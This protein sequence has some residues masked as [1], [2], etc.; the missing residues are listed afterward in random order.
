[1]PYKSEKQRKYLHSQKPE[2]AKKFDKHGT[3]GRALPAKTAKPIKGGNKRG[4]SK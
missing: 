2:V 1:M 3:K 4:R